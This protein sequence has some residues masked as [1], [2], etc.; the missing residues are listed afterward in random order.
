VSDELNSEGSLVDPADVESNEPNETF[1]DENTSSEYEGD[2]QPDEG[3]DQPEDDGEEIEFNEKSYKL[4]KDIAEAV[5][6]MRKDYTDKTMSL[7]EQRKSFEQQSSFHQQNI[8]DVASIV[9]INNQLAE[10]GQLDWNSLIDNDPVMAQKL[11]MQQQALTT[12]RDGLAQQVSQKQQH[13]NLEKQQLNAKQLEAS[14]SV[15]KRDISGWS[16]EFESKLQKFAVDRLGF[17]LDDIKT[18][19]IEPKVYKLLN[20]AYMGDQVLRK[21][22]TKPTLE[23]AKPVPILKGKSQTSNRN[24]AQMASGKVVSDDYLKW[25]RKG[26]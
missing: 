6:S 14:E 13:M 10:F 9:A 1:E 2:D 3:Q 5:K 17:D 7:A 12:K 15:L 23:S 21:Q 4:P 19:K 22:K 8:Q 11:Q 16:P 18:A 24:P 20:L 25:R 26:Y